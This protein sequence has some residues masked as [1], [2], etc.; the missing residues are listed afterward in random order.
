MQYL[1]LICYFKLFSNVIMSDRIYICKTNVKLGQ[2]LAKI[3][4]LIPLDITKF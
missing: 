4:M 1:F 2:I 3:L